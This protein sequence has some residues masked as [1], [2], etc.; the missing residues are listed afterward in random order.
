MTAPA[1]W[2]SGKRGSLAPWAQ[3]K[4]WAL[5]QVSEEYDLKL[6]QDD[7]AKSVTKVGG[8]HP[9]RKTI[10]QYKDSGPAPEISAA[11]PGLGRGGRANL[12]RVSYRRH[13]T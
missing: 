4:V 11:R 8:G 5:L 9:N 10:S 6:G 3:A 13:D 2:V 7:I 1:W 12:R